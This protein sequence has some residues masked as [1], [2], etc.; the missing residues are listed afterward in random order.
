MSVYPLSHILRFRRAPS[1]PSRSKQPAIRLLAGKLPP[2]T[3]FQSSPTAAPATIQSWI[4]LMT[5]GSAAKRSGH[6]VKR[7]APHTNTRGPMES[8]W[9]A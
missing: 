3:D 9:A 7:A 4:S 2:L 1:R 8:S 5:G 6:A